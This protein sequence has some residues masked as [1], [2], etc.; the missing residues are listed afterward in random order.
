M[1]FIKKKYNVLS[2]HILI[3][4]HIIFIAVNSMLIWAYLRAMTDNKN[5]MKL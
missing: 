4:D 2:S 5:K 1:T 3:K